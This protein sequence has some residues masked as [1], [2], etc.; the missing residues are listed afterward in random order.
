MVWQAFIKKNIRKLGGVYAPIIETIKGDKQS[1][2]WVEAV[3]KSFYLLKKKITK[4]PILS[5]LD[6]NKLFQVEFD[7]S[8]TAIGV[9]LSQERKHVAYFSEKLNEAKQKYTSYDK[10]FYAIVQALNKWRHYLMP[11]QFVI[12]IDNH[13]LQFINSQIKLSQRHVKW[14]E[15]LQNFTF[16]IRHISGKSNKVADALSKFNLILHEFQVNI[17]GFD[18]LK[19]MY[20]DDAIF[21]DACASYENPVSRYIIPWLA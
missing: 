16:V 7:A 14:V 20:K 18:E 21:K 10:E 17:L 19:E 11:K 13:A 1:F 15:F 5:L 6:F 4:Q 3:D 2:K 12:Y 9:V 8:G